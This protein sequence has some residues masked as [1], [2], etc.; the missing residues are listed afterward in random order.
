MNKKLKI[1]LVAAIALTMIIG[2]YFA[3]QYFASDSFAPLPPSPADSGS[4]EPSK[5]AAPIAVSKNEVFDFWINKLTSEIYYINP[6][7]QIFKIG[8]DG[9]EQQITPQS[10][11]DLAYIKPSFDGSAVLI[12][13][14][15]SK[16]PT[17][18]IFKSGTKSFS[19]LPSGTTAAAWDPSSNN[20]I[21]YLKNSGANSRLNIFT[22]NGQKSVEILKI[23]QYD[24]DLDWVRQDVVYLKTRPSN[25]YAGFILS[26]NI[27]SGAVK[28]IATGDGLLVRWFPEYKVGIEWLGKQLSVVDLDNKTLATINLKTIPSKCAFEQPLLFCAAVKNQNS[29]PLR[30]LPDNF[31]KKSLRR[32]EEV[33]ALL[34]TDL[35]TRQRLDIFSK[36]P[37]DNFLADRLTIHGNELL[38]LNDLD[39]KLYSL[40]L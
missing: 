33:Y 30:F 13:I 2:A 39:H 21:V 7:G 25:Q 15:H 11:S 17:F 31:L 24:L 36:L 40:P 14:G 26:Y 18:S 35:E 27:K 1:T 22:L 4:E 38:F 28:N 32:D 3:W 23:A 8:S 37:A 10:F 16:N 34:S 12:A 20:R 29:L 5:P 9:I 6:Q 19:P